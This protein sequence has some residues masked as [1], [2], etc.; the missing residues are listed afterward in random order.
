[1]R[2]KN[3]ET[4]FDTGKFVQKK[5]EKQQQKKRPRFRRLFPDYSWE[6]HAISLIINSE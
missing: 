6:I 2:G 3:H 5:Q 1:V 4:N